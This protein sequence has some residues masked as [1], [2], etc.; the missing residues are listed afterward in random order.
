MT[1]TPLALDRKK[2][3]YLGDAGPK[4]RGVF[5]AHDIRAGEVLESTPALLLNEKDTRRV[6]ATMLNQYAFTVGSISRTMRRRMK[7]S[8]ENRASC[9]IM[10]LITFC[11]HSENPNAEVLWEEK[12]GTL[13]HTLRATRRIP[14]HEE[15]CTSYGD[16]WFDGDGEGRL[17]AE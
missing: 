10:G 3:L 2:G 14:K 4:G 11:N 13:Y 6:E 15:I 1:G 5:C 12:D 7:V 16:G 8:N 9:M 17:R